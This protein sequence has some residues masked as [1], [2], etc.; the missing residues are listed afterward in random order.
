M[1][2]IDD[3]RIVY[4]QLHIVYI[5]FQPNIV[6]Y[7]WTNNVY[8]PLPSYLDFCGIFIIKRILE[9]NYLNTILIAYDIDDIIYKILHVKSWSTVD[10]YKIFSFLGM[11]LNIFRLEFCI[12]NFYA[13]LKLP[14]LCTC[15]VQF[16]CRTLSPFKCVCRLEC[17]KFVS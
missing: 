9:H 13:L 2:K 4:D 7:Y 1:C 14:K 3:E 12:V 15:Y 6:M 8:Y 17:N 10:H 11:K 16:A 5:S